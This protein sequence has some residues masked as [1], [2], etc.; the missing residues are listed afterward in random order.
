MSENENSES[1]SDAILQNARGPKKVEGDVGEVT[2][3]SL[4]DQIE[5]DK[6]VASKKATRKSPFG[7]RMTK[8]DP[9]GTN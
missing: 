1:L 2:Q 3:H 7:L 4:K 8:I 5:A 6:Y 9:D